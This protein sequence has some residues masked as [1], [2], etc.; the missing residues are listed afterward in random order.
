MSHENERATPACTSRA[1]SAGK[2]PAAL[3]FWK[4]GGWQWTGRQI[5]CQQFSGGEQ[6][7]CSV[8]IVLFLG[9]Q[10]LDLGVRRPGQEYERWNDAWARW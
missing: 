1:L 4:L 9:L 10:R 8:S 6:N 3:E 5:R 2:C 7:G